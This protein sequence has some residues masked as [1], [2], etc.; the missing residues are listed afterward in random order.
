MRTVGRAFIVR[1]YEHE[2]GRIVANI[3]TTVCGVVDHTVNQRRGDVLAELIL[4][5]PI[6]QYLRLPMKEDEGEPAAKARGG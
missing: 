4:E 6:G 5:R 2:N 1:P 3:A